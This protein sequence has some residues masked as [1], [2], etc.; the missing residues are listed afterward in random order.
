MEWAVEFTTEF[1]R[2][3]DSLTAEEQ[4]DVAASVNL[5]R[6][7]GPSLSRPHA[8]TLKNSRHSNMKELRTQHHGRPLRTLFAFDPRRTAILLLGGDKTG[9]NRFYDRMIPLADKLYDEH[10]QQLRKEGLL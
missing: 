4:E 6:I 1:E 8:D 10:L 3:W 2:W 9:D 5:L 7:T